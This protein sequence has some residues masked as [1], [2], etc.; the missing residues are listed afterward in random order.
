MATIQSLH[1]YK[2]NPFQIGCAD[3]IFVFRPMFSYGQRSKCTDLLNGYNIFCSKI[4]LPEPEL[5][6]LCLIILN[7]ALKYLILNRNSKYVH[8]RNLNI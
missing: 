7:P 8:E 4:F 6:S 3:G 2:Q 5:R 1:S